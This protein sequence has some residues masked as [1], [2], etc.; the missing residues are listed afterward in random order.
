MPSRDSGA[1]K[2]S[3]YGYDLAGRLDSVA[4]D[5]VVTRRY[6]YDANGNRTQERGVGGLLL[7]NGVHDEQDRLLSYGNIGEPV[8][9]GMD[10]VSYVLGVAYEW[11]AN[12]EL[13]R[14]SDNGA[15]E[16]RY[17]YDALGNL[18]GARVPGGDTLSYLADGQDRRVALKRNGTM[19]R[20]WL[21]GGA[22]PPIAELDGGGVLLHRY[23]Y[24]TLGHSPDLLVDGDSTTAYR[25]VTDHL[26]S[27]RA[28]V[29]TSDGALV[30]RT[31]YDAWGRVTA[32]TNATFQSLGY[33]GG[34]TDRST[35]LVRFGARDYDPEVGRWT[36]KDIWV[37][38][39]WCG[40]FHC[41]RLMPAG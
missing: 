25:V 8:P 13:V 39:L 29:R 2:V 38:R 33:A 32:M 6:Q 3:S 14:R 35:G 7:A 19:E 21:H 36:A 24:A 9:A 22:I 37:F 30:Q 16:S 20:Q 41:A 26:G 34:L 4:V 27:I 17:S 10:S 18:S 28:V 1:L 11:S 40:C 15:S 12:G 23:V 5:G 31:D